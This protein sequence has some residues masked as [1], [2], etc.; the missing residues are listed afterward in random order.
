MKKLSFLISLFVCIALVS[1]PA[2]GGGI[3]KSIGQTVYAVATHICALVPD[4]VT[5]PVP[6]LLT[7]NTRIII[8]NVDLHY[9]ITVYGVT[10][11]NPDGELEEEFLTD[12]VV[13][14]S[15]T[16]VTY[17]IPHYPDFS[18][19]P[20]WNILGGRPSFIVKWRAERPVHPPII[21]SA[22]AIVNRHPDQPL[23]ISFEG[24]EVIPGTVLKEDWWD[25]W[26]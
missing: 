11:Y 18:D 10:L 23:P 12:P 15:K 7:F 20:Y 9:P 8:R 5:V 1:T 22:N 21:T 13:I 24:F 6:C 25:R 17:G 2:L 26:W 4:P 16:A 3:K 19:I 14:E